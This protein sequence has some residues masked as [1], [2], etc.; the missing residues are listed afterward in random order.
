MLHDRFQ[1][2]EV[3]LESRSSRGGGFVG[4]AGARRIFR[5]RFVLPHVAF[6]IERSQVGNEV[7]IAHAQLAFEILKAPGTPRRQQSHDRKST[8]F[9][10]HAVELGEV[11]HFEMESPFVQ[12]RTTGVVARFKTATP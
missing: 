4:G 1:D 10:D 7:A 8:F 11:D 3:C 2:L 9:V 6:L 5:H 12:A